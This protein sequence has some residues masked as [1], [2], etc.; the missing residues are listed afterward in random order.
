MKRR[1]FI[2]NTGAVVLASP[3]MNFGSGYS[4]SPRM[5]ILGIDGMDPVITDHLMRKGELPNFRKLAQMGEFTMMRSTIPPQSPVAWGSFI[6]G[7]DPGVYGIFD[8]IHR[9]P[10]TYFPEFSISETVPSEWIVKLGKYRI[11]LKSGKVLLKREGKPFWDYLEEKDIEATIVKCPTN[12]PPSPSKQRTISGL[13]TPDILGGYGTYTLY[14]SDEV[15]SEKDISPNNLYYAY[16]NDENVMENGVIEGP[17]NDL[18]EDGEN[19]EVPF[20]VFLDYKHKTARIDI[21][22]KE[23]L[24]SENELSDWVEIKFSLIENIS[25]ITGMVKFY[26]MEMGKKFRL[27][28]SP[29]HMSPRDPA[30]SIS[31]PS[32]YSKELVE[33]VGLFHTISLPADTKALSQ[34]TFSME[35]FIVQSLSVFDESKRLFEYEF[36]RFLQ[37]KKGFLFFYFSAVD[38]GQHMCWALNDKEHPY[39]HPL[40][41]EKYGYIHH[42]LYRKHD[43]ILGQVLR[44][45]PKDISIIVHSD[46]G[47]NPYRRKVNINNWLFNQGYL[48]LVVD[49]IADEMSILEYADWGKTKAYFIGFNGVYLNLRGRE[50]SGIVTPSQKRKLLEEI[51][52]K[53]EQFRDPKTGER[54]IS[55]AYISEDHFSKD[56]LDRAPDIVVGFNKKYRSGDSSALGEFS[57]EEVADNMDWWSGDHLIDPLKVPATFISNFKINKRIPDMKDIAPTILK[58]FGIN[59]PSTMKGKSLI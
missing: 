46:H 23:I 42:E 11:P 53:L 10:K 15:E 13:G 39:F 30:L 34:A 41:H 8:F 22:D 51:K 29:I 59:N 35:N 5:I 7:A 56:Y 45:C 49:E 28:I 47:F 54:V 20:K 3:F 17:K 4:D 14:T 33:N 43:E 40:E 26:L 1:E 36:E 38:Q 18:V 6:T 48:K 55:N 25:S 44:K 52:G 31:T 58:F 57:V 37:K 50:S 32:S 2:K 16:I 19:I 9:D 27:Y 12:Y 21:Q 24:I